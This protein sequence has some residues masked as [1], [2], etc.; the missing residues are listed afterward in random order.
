MSKRSRLSLRWKLVFLS[1]AASCAAL[2][3]SAV[4]MLAY[5]YHTYRTKAG[6]D[7]CALASLLAGNSRAALVFDDKD[8]AIR[9]FE[10]F[11]END[12]VLFVG[13]FK[14]DGTPFAS[15]VKPGVSE[16][17]NTP[18]IKTGETYAFMSGRVVAYAG[19]MIDGSR[20]G[21]VCIGRSLLPLWIQLRTHGIVLALVMLFAMVISWLVVMHLQSGIAARI[22]SLTNTVDQVRR[23]EKFDIRAPDA[24]DDEIGLLVAEFN[25]MLE[26]VHVRD[27]AIAEH[28]AKLRKLASQ[29]VLTEEEERKR[30]AEELHDSICQL[31]WVAILRVRMYMKK[32]PE[33]D[34]TLLEDALELIEKSNAEARSLTF[35]MSSPELYQLGLPAALQSLASRMGKQYDLSID[36]E[37]SGSDATLSRHVAVTLHRAVRELLLNIYKHATA[38]HVSIRVEHQGE[39][40]LVEVKDDG[41]GFDPTASSHH[42]NGGGFGLFNIRE[43]MEDLVGS[44]EIESEPGVGTTVRLRVPVLSEPE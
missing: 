38:S 24:G 36:C 16:D 34:K 35:Q 2:A 25:A 8:A 43:R 6:E 29:I 10:P 4:L 21:C 32:H 20:V 1:T 9:N 12:N 28:R 17:L 30:L 40:L 18:L 31:L 13:V 39:S 14:A 15:I 37:N 22:E 7:A 5:E 11:F 26:R 23:D 44:C 3:L 19:I 27:E 33:G 41:K 42:E